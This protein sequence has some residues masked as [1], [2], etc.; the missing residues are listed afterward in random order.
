MMRTDTSI[1]YWHWRRPCLLRS[2]LGVVL[3]RTLETRRVSCITSV[4]P[5]SKRKPCSLLVLVLVL[6]LVLVVVWYY[7][8]TMVL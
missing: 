3:V 7:I 4:L 8:Y 5:A 1:R 2:M 6:A